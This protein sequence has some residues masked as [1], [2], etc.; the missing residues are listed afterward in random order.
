MPG[1]EEDKKLRQAQARVR[2]MRRFYS[3]LVTFVL[4]NL[5][6][7]VINL[8]ASPESLWFYWVT[9]IWGFV[10]VAQ[11]FN[12]FTIKDRFL[13]DEWEK[14]KVDELMKKDKR[15]K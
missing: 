6:L 2:R 10:L 5:L 7:I 3:N 1:S 15:K 12:T 11:A 4:I 8:I 14:K 13:G 9:L